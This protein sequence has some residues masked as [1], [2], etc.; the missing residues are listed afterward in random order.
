MPTQTPQPVGSPARPEAL[1]DDNY[2]E[3][4]MTKPHGDPLAEE[5]PPQT[6]KEKEPARSEPI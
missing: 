4:P 6:D 3:P 5:V 1:P 2:P